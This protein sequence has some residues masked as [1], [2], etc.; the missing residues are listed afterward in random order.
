MTLELG[1]WLFCFTNHAEMMNDLRQ[2]VPGHS[3]V[4]ELLRQWDVGTIHLD[5]DQVVIGE[6][7]ESWYRGVIGERVVGEVLSRLED[8][9]TV[10]HSVPVGRGT[11]DIDHVVIGNSGVFTINTKYSPGRDVWVA[12]RGMFVGG[13]KQ[14]YVLNS[15]AEARRASALLSRESGLTVPVTALIVFVDP[16]RITHK[17]AAGGGPD[18]PKVHVIRQHDLLNSIRTR[19]VFSHEQIGTIT[20]AALLPGTWHQPALP[21]TIGDHITREFAALEEAVGPRLAGPVARIPVPAKPASRPSR[22]R[23]ARAT[24]GSRAPSRGGSRRSRIELLI[25]EIA[26]P[27]AAFIG[28]YVWLSSPH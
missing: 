16:G 4:D 11:S 14:P 12:G 2:R 28:L 15:L 27:V 9:F 24:S 18:D 17:A 8:H 22:P 5:G 19:A 20:A 10:L 26:L 6:E 3:L 23:N 1:L 25:A 7:A 21:S 13:H